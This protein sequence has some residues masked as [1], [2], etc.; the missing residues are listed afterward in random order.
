M[1]ADGTREPDV[2]SFKLITYFAPAL[3][4]SDIEMTNCFGSTRHIVVG[5]PRNDHFPQRVLMAERSSPADTDL[6]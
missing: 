1:C 4:S 6:S 2:P 3:P 5:L